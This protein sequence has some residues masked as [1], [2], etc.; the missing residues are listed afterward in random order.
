MAVGTADRDE[1]AV[2]DEKKSSPQSFRSV[3][4]LRSYVKQNFEMEENIITALLWQAERVAFR[5]SHRNREYPKPLQYLHQ[6][7]EKI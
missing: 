4:S 7:K 1:S 3:R 2:N 6:R 5:Q